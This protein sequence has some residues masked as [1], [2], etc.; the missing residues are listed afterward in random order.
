MRDKHSEKDARHIFA[1]IRIHDE[2]LRVE[3]H[4]LKFEKATD[5]GIYI[6]VTCENEL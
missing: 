4:V 5:T 2:V 1:L 6:Q 3:Q